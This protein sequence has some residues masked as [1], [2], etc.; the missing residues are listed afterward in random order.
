M[1]LRPG[2]FRR[3]AAGVLLLGALAGAG[4][5]HHEDL[6]GASGAPAERF[7]S[8]HSPLSR[9]AHWHSAVRAK[10][11]PCLACQG[12][13]AAGLALAARRE[14]PLTIAFFRGADGAVAVD[15][16]AVRSNGSRAPPALL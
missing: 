9:A 3:L 12:Q 5:H 4:L 15:S 16:P 1:T 7:L 13:R 10:D 8:S 2:L 6:V 14:A 11:D